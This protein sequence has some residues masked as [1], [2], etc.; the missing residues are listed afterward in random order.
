MSSQAR[1]A[2]DSSVDVDFDD[3][4]SELDDRQSS[5]PQYEIASYP[6]DFTLDGLRLKWDAGDIVIPEFQRG[7]V[8]TI[9]QASKLIESF[10][11]GLPVPSIFF[12][13]E[14]E[15]EKSL[16]VDGQQRLRTIFYYF[17]GRF[18]EERAGRQQVFRLKG[19]SDDSPYA[20][21]TYQ[22]LLDTDEG[23]ARRL[24]N[25]VLRAFIIRQIDPHDDTSIFHIFER[26]NTGGTL[27][28]N[29]EVRNAVCTGNFNALLHELNLLGEWREVI[30]K[31]RP[32]SR[33]RDVELI[34]RFFALYH[35]SD[36][37]EKPMK[38]FMSRYMRRHAVETEAQIED[39]QVEFSRT[40]AAVYSKLGAKPF[41]IFAGLN[42]SAFDSVFIAFARNIDIIP[43][44][45]A[46]RYYNLISSEDFRAV[47]RGG[48][49][50]VDQVHTRMEIA[51]RVLFG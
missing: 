24:R 12:Y 11:V 17:D 36:R 27:L 2:S 5:P 13:T 43:D 32:D 37:Y 22:E 51:N 50:D 39:Y 7:F 45:I 42:S 23:A 35:A 46:D 40:L 49:T 20:N 19:L 3:P 29:Q 21:K 9:A 48:T 26:L 33:M 14:R 38:D 15:T 1:D 30:G 34:L 4:A 25:G 28:H 18:G 41:H 10:L 31:P 8:W 44:D 16:V 6:A 47:I